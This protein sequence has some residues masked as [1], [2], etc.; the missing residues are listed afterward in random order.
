MLLLLLLNRVSRFLDQQQDVLWRAGSEPQEQQQR[1]L[2][3]QRADFQR[4]QSLVPLYI[5]G[6]RALGV[7]IFTYIL[8]PFYLFILLFFDIKLYL[9]LLLKDWVLL[10]TYNVLQLDHSIQFGNAATCVW[11]S[12][13]HGV[14]VT[15]RVVA[16]LT[17][18]CAGPAFSSAELCRVE[19][20]CCAVPCYDVVWRAVLSHTSSAA[21]AILQSPSL[22]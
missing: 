9:I 8:F 6:V 1:S 19:C 10:L 17:A 11:H 21:H 20:Q 7:F 3:M 22:R 18:C 5:A 12:G 13:P 15:H 16:V 2:S 4:T 14:T